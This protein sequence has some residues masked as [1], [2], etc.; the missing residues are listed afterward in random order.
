[1]KVTN[2]ETLRKNWLEYNQ[3][4]RLD[5]SFERY[6]EMSKLNPTAQVIRHVMN[7]VSKDVYVPKVLRELSQ[8]RKNEEE[9]EKLEEKLKETLKPY[10]I[11]LPDDES[12][13]FILKLIIRDVSEFFEKK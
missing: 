10:L 11:K 13:D 5:I 3:T 12:R 2:E 7:L 6:V 1:M 8:K 9:M 4:N